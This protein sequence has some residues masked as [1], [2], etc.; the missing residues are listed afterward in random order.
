LIAYFL[1]L[2]SLLRNALRTRQ[3]LLLENLA[4]RQ[5]LAVLSRQRRL[6]RLHPSDRLFWSWLSRIWSG[7]RSALVLVQAETVVRWQ[8][9]A[10]RHYWAWR[11]RRARGRPPVLG[12][13]RDLIRRLAKENPSGSSASQHSRYGWGVGTTGAG[14]R[15]RSSRDPHPSIKRRTALQNSVVFAVPP[16]SGVRCVPSL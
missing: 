1:L 3:Q 9:T 7:W 16:W 5:Q 4:L 10:W 11:S 8:R 13:V 2:C 12:E 14:R 6:P 15:R